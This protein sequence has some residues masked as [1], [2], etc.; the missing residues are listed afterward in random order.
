MTMTEKL[1]S[2]KFW[3]CV[4]AFLASIGV[5]ISGVATDNVWIIG[6]GTVCSIVSAAI[7]AAAEAS[8]DKASAASTT[9]NV[10]ASTDDAK[11]VE[12]VITPKETA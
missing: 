12:S 3:I 6:I 10:S 9:T 2:R 1:K 4:A 5:G 7:Y 8:V 11:I